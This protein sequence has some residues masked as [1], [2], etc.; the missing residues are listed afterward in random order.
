MVYAAIAAIVGV[1][2]NFIAA[3]IILQTKS[4]SWLIFSALGVV[5][6]LLAAYFTLIASQKKTLE[7][8]NTKVTR[9]FELH[10]RR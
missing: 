6:S 4:N 10:E 3:S 5:A 2:G 8:S 7:V 9:N 1:A